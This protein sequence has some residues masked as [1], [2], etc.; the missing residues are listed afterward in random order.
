MTLTQNTA[1]LACLRAQ[2]ANAVTDQDC[3]KLMN[4]IARL[5]RIVSYQ[6]H[7]I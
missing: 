5:S 2:L 6:T 7:R 1:L 3:V 4:R